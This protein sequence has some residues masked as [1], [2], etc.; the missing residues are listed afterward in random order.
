MKTAEEVNEAGAATLTVAEVL[1]HAKAEVLKGESCLRTAAEWLAKAEQRGV[2]QRQ[3]ADAVGKSVGWVNGLLKWRKSGYTN[4]TAFG[5]QAKASRQRKNVQAT[6]QKKA[7]AAT[8]SEQ[9][10]AAAER[11]R[12][13]TANADTDAGR[14]ESVVLPFK[15]P[16]DDG[17]QPVAEVA[18]S[19]GTD[20]RITADSHG[21]DLDI[22]AF[23]DRQPFSDE[24]NKQLQDLERAWS[25]F[26]LAWTNASSRVQKNFEAT[27][28]PFSK[29]PVTSSSVAVDAPVVPV[30]E[31][32]S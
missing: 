13:E 8:S 3:M 15:K 21:G 14:C 23:L 6:E 22:P 11:A 29:L 31:V 17:K 26:T 9:V 18:K 25:S 4:E 12:A 10:H 30:A 19:N 7:Q 28:A 20:A 24:E 32:R 5:P 2:K 27:N 1:C 16:A